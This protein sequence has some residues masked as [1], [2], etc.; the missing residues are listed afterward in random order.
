MWLLSRTPRGS[1][2]RR[3]TALDEAQQAFSREHLESKRARSQGS[4]LDL[5]KPMVGGG[6]HTRTPHTRHT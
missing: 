6:T 2:E 4:A 1:R 3:A 5:I